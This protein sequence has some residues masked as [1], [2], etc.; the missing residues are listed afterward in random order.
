MKQIPKN[1]ENKTNCFWGGK[2]PSFCEECEGWKPKILKGGNMRSNIQVKK[3]I[4]ALQVE[5]KTLPE[6]SN[7]GD[8]NWKIIDVQI[9]VLNRFLLNFWTHGD[10]KDRLD[11]LLEDYGG[12]FPDKPIDKAKCDT[13][14]W[15][16][17]NIEDL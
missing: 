13:Y 5:R 6:Y 16:L 17:E 2:I 12:D 4:K 11:E 14:D 3:K 7:F 9:R 1:C 8:E 10:T 15:L